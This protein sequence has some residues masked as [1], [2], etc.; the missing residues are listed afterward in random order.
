M[1]DVRA[2]L[3]KRMENCE[4]CDVD[5]QPDPEQECREC[6]ARA[7]EQ[8]RITGIGP[9]TEQVLKIR[10]MVK[11][12][13]QFQADDLQHWQWECLVAVDQAVEAHRAEEMRKKT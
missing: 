8:G 3:K 4:N 7:L 2:I 13:Y 1:A 11:I 6:M 10:A 5:D 9:E 12:G